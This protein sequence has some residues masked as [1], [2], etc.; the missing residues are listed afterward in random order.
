MVTDRRRAAKQIK[1]G[2]I[3]EMATSV[4][5]SICAAMELFR[6]EWGVFREDAVLLLLEVVAVVM[7]WSSSSRGSD[8]ASG[9][10]S[11][12]SGMAGSLI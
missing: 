1:T 7:G 9:V 10:N 3:P 4:S 12:F 2:P 11:I 6:G 8:V 5:R